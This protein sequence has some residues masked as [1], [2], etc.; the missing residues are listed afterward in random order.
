MRCCGR[1]DAISKQGL[2]E[3][4][5]GIQE[6]RPSVEGKVSMSGG[7]CVS[8]GL[9]RQWKNKGWETETMTRLFRLKQQKDETW[10]DF[11]I[12]TCNMARKIW[13]Q[14]GLPSV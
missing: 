6:Q 1:A 9:S 14:M 12:R 7:P 11:H 8:R 5:R 4:Q 2:L 13:V 3:G 10:V